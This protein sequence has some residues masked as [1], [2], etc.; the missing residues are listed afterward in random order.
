VILP[1]HSASCIK[2]HHFARI[3]A[4]L[5]LVSFLAAIS[6]FSQNAEEKKFLLKDRWLLEVKVASTPS[7][8]TYQQ[9]DNKTENFFYFTL[10][11]RFSKTFFEEYNKQ[12]T[13]K[14]TMIGQAGGRI[15]T[16]SPSPDAA[17]YIEPVEKA[18]LSFLRVNL[19]AHKV[20][21][22]LTKL[23]Q[24]DE[25]LNEYEYN[26]LILFPIINKKVEY[27]I[28]EKLL[29]LSSYPTKEKIAFIKKTKRRGQYLN[30]KEARFIKKYL[31][32]GEEILLLV[33]FRNFP[34]NATSFSILV[35]GIVDPIVLA[36]K[37]APEIETVGKFK[38]LIHIKTN[39]QD[40]VLK[41]V[42]AMKNWQLENR[43][44]QITYDFLGDPYERH[45]D[46]PKLKN[47]KTISR[48]LGGALN[49]QTFDNLFDVLLNDK[50]PL[51][52][53]TAFNFL[54]AVL[55]A[56]IFPS[57]LLNKELNCLPQSSSKIEQLTKSFNEKSKTQKIEPTSFKISCLNLN[58][59]PS[60]LEQLKFNWI[61]YKD[62]VLFNP[63]NFSYELKEESILK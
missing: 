18:P 48:K 11:V 22:V 1:Y 15:L 52:R 4:K 61:K 59:K 10:H 63:Q 55:P 28:L 2:I 24:Q 38:G 53:I 16:I 19:L 8:F 34:N 43:Y 21:K 37:R 54:K 41:S 30:L 33:Y 17:Y 44:V 3:P 6:A 60:C 13:Y 56:D 40:T 23:S 45:L 47:V 35:G 51:N 32:K 36:S 50:L 14:E 57:C 27:K 7:L 9:P 20:V 62:K 49:I 5:L 58:I 12:R 29:K 25:I 42:T 31:N 39:A 26:D 46:L